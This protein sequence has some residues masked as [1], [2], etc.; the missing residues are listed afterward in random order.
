MKALADLKF[1]QPT[2]IQQMTI[3]KLMAEGSKDLIGLASTGTGKTAAFAIPALE[4]IDGSD[5]SIQ[6]L[7]M[8]PTRELAQ[9]VGREFDVLGKYTD[10]KVVVINGGASYIKQKNDLRRGAQV[11]VATPGRLI[12]LIKQGVLNLANVHTVVLDEADEMISMGFREHIESILDQIPTKQTW[13]FS[14]TMDQQIR[15]VA[16]KYLT[17]PHMVQLNSDQGLSPLIESFYFLVKNEN[18]VT[19]L[20]RLILKNPN[21]YGLIFCQTKAEVADVEGELRARGLAIES[22]HGDKKQSEREVVLR[23]LKAR[24]IS[25]VVATDVAARGLDVKD[26]T[27]VVNYNLPW[28]AESFVHR[29][30]RTGRNGQKGTTW[31]FI[32]PS[33]QQ[34]LR[35]FQR[36]L[37]FQWT[38][39]TIPSLTESLTERIQVHIQGF[40]D[41]AQSPEIQP[42]LEKFFE[43][44]QDSAMMET[45]Q[46]MEPKELIRIF[47][48]Q[49]FP[50]ILERDY[51]VEY[52]A[53]PQNDRYSPRSS[54]G[55]ESG[56]YGGGGAGGRRGGG[57]GGDYGRR[58]RAAG[59]TEGRTPY[60]GG[61]SR[62]RVRHEDAPAA[63]PRKPS[64]RPRPTETSDSPPRASS[65]I[66]R[67]G[68]PAAGRNPSSRPSFAARNK[69]EGRKRF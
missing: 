3:P 23:K 58:P 21:F 4:R 1:E 35:N 47:F 61:P 33:Q 18:K 2:P 24:Q 37:G 40:I 36:Q 12:D 67:T 7:V 43:R 6:V 5:R 26:L 28:E 32:S 69:D 62:D 64:F 68:R 8:S 53:R 57:G 65:G 25:A 48:L 52:E 59:P 31:S 11:C 49:A 17:T 14:A 41:Q 9:Q 63:G 27:H 29:S 42:K 54:A 39:G 46:S 15:R 20:Q 10:K 60:A 13:L 38:K 44:V 50:E 16:Q 45:L 30:G 55:G 51:G 66:S 56:R 34:Q 22:L 19:A